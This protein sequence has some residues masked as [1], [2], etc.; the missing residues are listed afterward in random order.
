M[1]PER[2]REVAHDVCDYADTHGYPRDK[3][4]DEIVEDM[5]YVMEFNCPE[6]LLYLYDFIDCDLGVIYD[7]ITEVC[8]AAQQY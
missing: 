8:E 7:E 6:L 5:R 3:D 4:V 2:M 1:T